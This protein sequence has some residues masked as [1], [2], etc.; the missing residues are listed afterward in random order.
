M[1]AVADS[2]PDNFW[3]SVIDPFDFAAGDERPSRR[4]NGG[5]SVMFADGHVAYLKFEN[6]ASKDP[7]LVRRWNYTNLPVEVMSKDWDQHVPKP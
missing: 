3:D 4:H 2:T 6:I 5:C 7:W 1:I